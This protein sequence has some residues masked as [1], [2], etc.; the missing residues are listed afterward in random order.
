MIKEYYRLNNYDPGAG[1]GKL[2]KNNSVLGNQTSGQE[3]V[4]HIYD[5]APD[6]NIDEEEM[7]DFV[8]IISSKVDGHKHVADLGN[9]KDNAT[10]ANNNH[11]SIFEYAGKHKN[12]VVKGLSP[13]LTYRSKTNTKGPALGVQSTAAYI[14][15]RPGR[16]SGTQYGTSRKHKILTFR[17]KKKSNL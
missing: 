15:N 14:R 1:Y 10:L 11:T 2:G 12:Y 9:R 5:L 6:N 4:R 3:K 16:K 17:P 13:R 8:N 7:D